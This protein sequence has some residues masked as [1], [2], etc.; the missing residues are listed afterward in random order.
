MNNYDVYLTFKTD[1][2][3]SEILKFIAH[4]LGKSQPDLINEICKDF[5]EMLNEAA[6]EKIPPEE[7]GGK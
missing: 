2:A 1:K 7:K 3:T 5:I 4:K 6:I